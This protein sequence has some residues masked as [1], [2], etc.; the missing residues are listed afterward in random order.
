MPDCSADCAAKACWQAAQEAR[1]RSMA[2]M[3]GGSSSWSR[4]ASRRL[5]GSAQ[6]MSVL[7]SLLQIQQQ[8]FARARKARHHGAEGNA[9]DRRDFLVGQVF[10][11]APPDDFAKLLGQLGE[12]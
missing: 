8:K 10:H 5:R 7:L 6:S 3:P 12:G 9:G 2:M 4:Y 11:P 1:C